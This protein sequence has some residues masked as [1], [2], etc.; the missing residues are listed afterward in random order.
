MTTIRTLAAAAVMAC[1]T[2]SV[3]AQLKCDNYALKTSVDGDDVFLFTAGTSP[4]M[5][6]TRSGAGETM[7]TLVATDGTS[8][9]TVSVSAD[10]ESTLTV[11]KE[12]LYTVYS[13]GAAVDKVWWLSPKPASVDFTVDSVDCDAVY[14]TAV[15]EAPDVV[16]GS[17]TLKQTLTFQ[18]ET[19][20]S[21]IATTKNG[22]A[23]LEGLYDE[24]QLT[25]KAVNQAFN[26]VAAT[27]SVF[28]IGVMASY[29][30]EN[31]KD[32][33]INEVTE[34]GEAL[35]APADVYFTNKSRGSFTVCEWEIGTAARLY[36]RD[37]MYQFQQPGTYALK[38]IVTNEETGCASVD[39]SQ[40]VTITE[41]ALEFP[42]AFTPNGD[43]VNDL[44]LPAFRSLKKYELN[45][46][47]RWG[48]RVFETK[49]PADGWDGKEGNAD[50]A[51]GT[52]YYVATAEGYE[53]GVSLK[54]KGSIT[55]VR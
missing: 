44:F 49:D 35:S 53:K 42:N 3:M 12:G 15:A 52:Y 28:P 21:I 18:W 8:T 9:D 19:G 39:S 55:L 22:R 13:G 31:R 29:S 17:H 7:W 45:I 10:A 34:T 25:V 51:A 26:E 32:E 1:M 36:D 11:E 14:A 37:P 47:N 6:F 24:C 4:R 33:I 43:G 30:I 38:L 50:A 54:R 41:A 5:T 46:Y 16:F 40:T 27:D 20:D 2:P 23:E 48:R